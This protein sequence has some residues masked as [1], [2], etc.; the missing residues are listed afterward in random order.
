MLAKYGHGCSTNRDGPSGA[1]DVV[2]G[3]NEDS[4]TWKVLVAD[5]ER[6]PLVPIPP[7]REGLVGGTGG[8]GEGAV[9]A[10]DLAHDVEIGEVALV[11]AGEAQLGVVE[12]RTHASLLALTF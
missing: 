3:E 8:K 11:E 6:D 10:K 5:G 4:G 12:E 9:S 2:D 7:R 1:V